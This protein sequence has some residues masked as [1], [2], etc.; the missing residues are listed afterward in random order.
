MAEAN[1]AAVL[2]WAKVNCFAELEL[3]ANAPRTHMEIILQVAANFDA[4]SRRRGI[5]DVCAEA[6]YTAKHVIAKVTAPAVSRERPLYEQRRAI[7]LRSP[8]EASRE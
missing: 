5:A 4:E 3:K 8:V 6:L 1:P 2:A 7:A